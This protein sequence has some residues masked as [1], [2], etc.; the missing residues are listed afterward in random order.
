MVHISLSVLRIKA[1]EILSFGKRSECTDINDLC[2]TSLEKR[3]TVNSR[4]DS[5]ITGQ[6]TDLIECT[7]VNTDML[8]EEVISYDLLLQLIDSIRSPGRKTSKSG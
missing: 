7:A 5:D 3:R 8:S 6:W 1:L 2:L 4:N